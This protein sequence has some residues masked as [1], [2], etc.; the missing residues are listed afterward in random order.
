MSHKHE[1]FI[2]AASLSKMDE[3]FELFLQVRE[4]LSLVSLSKM[5]G[6]TSATIDSSV[7]YGA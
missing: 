3:F 4:T 7:A 5:D 2:E 1:K 6:V